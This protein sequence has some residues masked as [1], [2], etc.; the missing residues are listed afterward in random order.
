MEQFLDVSEL[1]APEPLE[2][3]LDSLSELGESQYLHVY[4]RMEPVLLYD[5]LEPKGFD[6]LST[7]DA[8]G[9]FHVFI[10]KQGDVAAEALARQ[11]MT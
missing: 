9:M 10:W 7:R 3:V 5:L 2:H 8:K 4:H 11:V 6:R 1:E